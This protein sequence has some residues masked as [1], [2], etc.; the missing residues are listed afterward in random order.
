MK[1][2]ALTLALALGVSALN[3]LAQD[4]NPSRHGDAPP[5]DEARPDRDVRKDERVR[6]QSKDGDRVQRAEKDRR[7]PAMRD[8][9]QLE[10]HPPRLASRGDTVRGGPMARQQVPRKP[11]FC[12]ECG[13]PFGPAVMADRGGPVMGPRQSRGPLAI[14]NGPEAPQPPRQSFAPAQ[15]D[16]AFRPQKSDD[17]HDTPLPRRDAPGSEQ[18]GPT[19]VE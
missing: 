3:A 11:A 4:E 10:G 1:T 8:A 15:R 17:H 6:P 14:R 16:R 7:G 5:R 13:R 12:S 9:Q 2:T 18:R 19:P